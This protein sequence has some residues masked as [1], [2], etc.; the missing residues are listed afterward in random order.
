MDTVFKVLLGGAAL[1]V[2]YKVFTAAAASQQNPWA[3][4]SHP[5]SPAPGFRP[6]QPGGLQAPQNEPNALNSPVLVE[7][8]KQVGS[9]LGNLLNTYGHQPDSYDY[10]DNTDGMWD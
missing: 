4:P 7:G 1:Y 5:P 3:Q 8:V 10:E 6:G 2:G 9:L